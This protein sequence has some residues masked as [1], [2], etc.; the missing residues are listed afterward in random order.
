MWL[1]VFELLIDLDLN[2]LIFKFFKIDSYGNFFYMLR[3][4]VEVFIV[5]D[6]IFCEFEVDVLV[7]FDEI[8]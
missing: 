8:G 1:W 2:V 4:V 6:N 5:L 7:V 3:R